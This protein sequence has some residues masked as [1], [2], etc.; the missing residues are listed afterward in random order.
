MKIA[1]LDFLKA[2]YGTDSRR[3][4]TVKSALMIAA[5]TS[6]LHQKDAQQHLEQTSI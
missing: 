5:E 2:F 3:F 4:G 6:R 1:V